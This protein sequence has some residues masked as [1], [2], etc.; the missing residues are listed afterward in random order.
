MK[1][2]EELTSAIIIFGIAVIVILFIVNI[3]SKRLVAP[4]NQLSDFTKKIAKGEYEKTLPDPS[5][6]E[7]SQF[8]S[9]F[10]LMSNKLKHRE[11]ELREITAQL[12]D[13]VTL[14]TAELKEAL[15]KSKRLS[16]ALDCG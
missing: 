12:E 16:V 8:T 13:R 6:A 15:Y 4:L 11:K 14:R 2:E 9:N 10:S 1:N 5:Y 3:N 7:I